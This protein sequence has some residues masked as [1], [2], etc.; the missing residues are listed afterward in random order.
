MA[1]NLKAAVDIAEA[2]LVSVSRIW[3]FCL[4]SL[5]FKDYEVKCVCRHVTIQRKATHYY[6]VKLLTTFLS[7]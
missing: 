3:T 4:N 7:I 2:G 5:I 1:A 6:P